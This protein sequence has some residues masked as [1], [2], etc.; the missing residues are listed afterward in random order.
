MA[1][2]ECEGSSAR[3]FRLRNRLWVSA[4][5]NRSD[6]ERF[7]A[8]QQAHLFRYQ[9]SLIEQCAQ[10]EFM[11]PDRNDG[12]GHRVSAWIR[13]CKLHRESSLLHDLPAFPS[14]T[15][16]ASDPRGNNGC[17]QSSVA[18]NDAHRAQ[19]HGQVNLF[20]SSLPNVLRYC[21]AMGCGNWFVSV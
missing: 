14:P 13:S 3:A 17:T 10:S 21:S 4:E 2:L 18:L 1:I 19:S 7:K 6:V 16:D 12:A 15:Q 11:R 5:S 9:I 20:C 8:S